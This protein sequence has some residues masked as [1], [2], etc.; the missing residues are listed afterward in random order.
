MT[1]IKK[2]KLKDIAKFERAKK[3]KVYSKGSTLIQ[4]SASKGEVEYLEKVTEVTEGKYAIVMPDK[5]IN[6]KYFNIVVEKNIEHFRAK[7]QAG[8]NIQIKDIG[9]MIIELHDREAQDIIASHIEMIE[10][11][12]KTT[13]TEIHILNTLKSRFLRDL[14]V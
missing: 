5:E 11:E 9:K 13:S 8:L 10:S 3:G 14:F 1:K 7:Y 12:E 2:Y 4:I 6:P